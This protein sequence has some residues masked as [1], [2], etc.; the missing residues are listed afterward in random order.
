V[1]LVR[2]KQFSTTIP[3]GVFRFTSTSLRS[4]FRSMGT[5]RSSQYQIDQTRLILDFLE[6]TAR[7]DVGKFHDLLQSWERKSTFRRR[8]QLDF[9]NE[10]STLPSALRREEKGWWCRLSDFVAF[11]ILSESRAA[12][13]SLGESWLMELGNR[14]HSELDTCH[15]SF[16]SSPHLVN[17]NWSFSTECLADLFNLQN[18][19]EYLRV[20]PLVC[21]VLLYFPSA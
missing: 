6:R 16:P 2:I 11:S 20:I 12:F 1:T 7:L 18:S 19:V 15:S 8:V 5:S 13:I 3:H 21:N 14:T 17:S 9:R 10:L 4:F